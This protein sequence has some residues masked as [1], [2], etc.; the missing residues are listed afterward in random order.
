MIKE[1]KNSLRPRMSPGL[2]RKMP[3]DIYLVIPAGKFCYGEFEGD[4]STTLKMD[5]Q[6]LKSIVTRNGR[7]EKF[8]S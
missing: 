7:K 8:D 2:R 6:Q 1:S 4:V 5:G 3:V